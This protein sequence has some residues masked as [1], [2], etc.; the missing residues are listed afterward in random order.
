MFLC[1][2]PRAYI[3]PSSDLFLTNFRNWFTFYWFFSCHFASFTVFHT[4]TWGREA[5]CHSGH[6]SIREV[7]PWQGAGRAWLSVVAVDVVA[8][9]CRCGRSS[10]SVPTVRM[11]KRHRSKTSTILSSFKILIFLSSSKNLQSWFSAKWLPAS[12]LVC[13]CCLFA[14]SFCTESWL[15]EEGILCTRFQWRLAL[16]QR[17]FLRPAREML[18]ALGWKLKKCCSCTLIARH[19]FK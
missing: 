12:Q 14:Y 5:R 13:C 18:S 11:W 8:E 19:V 17:T 15:W 3:W 9:R 1:Q 7:S 2:D 10:S 6:R 4:P 16:L